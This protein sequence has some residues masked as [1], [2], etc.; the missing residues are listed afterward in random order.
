MIAY[1]VK[2]GEWYGLMVAR[3]RRDMYWL[4]DELGDPNS[5]LIQKV[6]NCGLM[7]T[8]DEENSEISDVSERWVD[9]IEYGKWVDPKWTEAER[10]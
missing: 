9:A 5:C 4:I 8:V 2:M 10:K 6:D 3:N 7:I 1:M